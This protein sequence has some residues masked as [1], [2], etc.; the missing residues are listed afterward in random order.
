MAEI[1]EYDKT[2]MKLYQEW[3][4]LRRNLSA[5]SEEDENES[6]EMQKLNK[7]VKD[8]IKHLQ[9]LS[10]KD[11]DYLHDEDLSGVPLILF[12]K[13]LDQPIIEMA[14]NV[15]PSIYARFALLF[16]KEVELNP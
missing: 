10:E 15:N 2:L 16:E 14:D 3:L 12:K 9:T 13:M 8:P 5:W 1:E 11:L 7:S 6:E 4:E